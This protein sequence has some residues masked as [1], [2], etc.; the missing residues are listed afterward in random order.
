[1]YNFCFSDSDSMEIDG[2]EWVVTKFEQTPIM[3][4]YLLAFTIADFTYKLISSGTNMHVCCFHFYLRHLSAGFFLCF[5]FH[6]LLLWCVSK[7]FARREAIAAGHADY[8][9][10]ITQ[11]ILIHYEKEFGWKYPLEK[12][13]ES[14]GKNNEKVS[15]ALLNFVFFILIACINTYGW[16]SPLI[17]CV[18]C[19]HTTKSYLARYIFHSD[20]LVILLFTGICCCMLTSNIFCKGLIASTSLLH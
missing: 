4:T 1:M 19:A 15:M 10:E 9:A 2:E 17:K 6:K 18:F 5:T 8:A 14:R 7:I 3:S 20:N 13:G 11:K 16:S 12:L